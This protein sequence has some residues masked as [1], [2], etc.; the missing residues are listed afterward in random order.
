MATFVL[1][2]FK[3]QPQ[4]LDQRAEL[5]EKLNKVNYK[6]D[7]NNIIITTNSLEESRHY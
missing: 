4:Q 5:T 7:S 1:T 6:G 2:L 3:N